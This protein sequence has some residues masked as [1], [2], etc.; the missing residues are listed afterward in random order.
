[1]SVSNPSEKRYAIKRC[2]KQKAL[3]VNGRVG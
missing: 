3:G 2:G 1:M